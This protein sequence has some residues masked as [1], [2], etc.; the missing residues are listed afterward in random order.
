MTRRASVVL[1]ALLPLGCLETSVPSA[2]GCNDCHG[3]LETAA[4]P[5]GLGGFTEP[6]KIGIG[7]HAAHTTGA[8][9]GTPVACEECHIIPE[10]TDSPGHVD[11]A[12]PAEVKWGA[13]AKTD[14]ATGEWSHDN[15]TC[16]GTY[17]HGGTL[18]GGA[19][20]AVKWTEVAGGQVRCNS[21][22]GMPP[23]APHPDNAACESCH[24]PTAGAGGTIASPASHIDGTLDVSGMQ[25]DP[26]AGCH[27][28]AQSLAPPPDSA[29]VTDTSSRTVGAHRVHVL[30]DSISTPVACGDCHVVPAATGDAGHIDGAPAE[31]V[32]GGRAVLGG[33]N[34]TWDGTTCANTYCHDGG[35]GTATDP[36]WTTVDGS[37]GACTSCHGMPPPAPHPGSTRCDNCHLTMGAEGGMIGDPTTHIDG[38][39][40]LQ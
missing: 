20:T 33:S 27:G 12:W 11:T 35:G 29:G 2:E 16:S 22:H 14:A 36:D 10:A 6:T 5:R 18:T 39:V 25:G 15:A 19:I 7:A 30:G 3:G 40:Q 17:C 34:P 38:V 37:Q 28:D 9:L 4:P 23:P 8:I 1:F 31:V 21:C 26:C 32:F 24:A 13:L